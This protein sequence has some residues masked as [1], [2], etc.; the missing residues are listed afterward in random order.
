MRPIK[1]KSLGEK[2]LILLFSFFSCLF[3]IL[4][5]NR[6]ILASNDPILISSIVGLQRSPSV[7]YSDNKNC[8]IVWEDNRNGSFDI[9]GA[10]VYENMVLGQILICTAPG[11]QINPVIEWNGINYFVVWQDKRNV[12]SF[13]LFGAR[14][15][16]MGILLDL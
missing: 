14:V 4:S 7:A 1:E 13:D 10:V 8:F 16:K 6:N 11:D 12:N 15:S 3:I 2:N 5:N 9:F